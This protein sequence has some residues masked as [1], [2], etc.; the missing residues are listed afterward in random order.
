MKPERIDRFGCK[1][2]PQ[3]FDANCASAAFLAAPKDSIRRAH[4]RQRLLTT[5]AHKFSIHFLGR[6]LVQTL[7]QVDFDFKQAAGG[8]TFGLAAKCTR[9]KI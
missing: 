4:F 1:G 8:R 9:R 2:A 7:A 3:K 5:G 6:N